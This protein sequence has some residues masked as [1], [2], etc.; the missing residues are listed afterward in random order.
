MQCLNIIACGIKFVNDRKRRW[1]WR[2]ENEESE[3][4]VEQ[5]RIVLSDAGWC[6]DGLDVL[7]K[8]AAQGAKSNEDVPSWSDRA[9][10]RGTALHAGTLPTLNLRLHS[11]SHVLSFSI[12]PFL[13]FFFF[14]F[15]FFGFFF[16]VVVVFVCTRIDCFT[17]GVIPFFYLTSHVCTVL[18]CTI[19]YVQCFLLMPSLSCRHVAVFFHDAGMHYLEHT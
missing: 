15:F 17:L 14:F 11:F 3:I 18:M 2:A 13:S 9:L 4:G 5:Q 1:R 10:E 6:A 8:G 16:V 12:F 7:F 19:Y